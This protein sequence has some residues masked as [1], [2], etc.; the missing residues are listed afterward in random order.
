M[1]SLPIGALFRR[2]VYRGLQETVKEGSGNGVSLYG[3]SMRRTWTDGPFTRVPEGYI[4]DGYG[5]IL[6]ECKALA[7]L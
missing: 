1:V 7:S 6:C 3:N 5:D 2:F 4:K